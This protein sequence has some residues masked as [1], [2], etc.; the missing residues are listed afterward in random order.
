MDERSRH[1][2]PEHPQAPATAPWPTAPAPQPGAPISGHLP[3]AGGGF[4]LPG[5]ANGQPALSAHGGTI[6]LPLAPEHA[7][8]AIATLPGHAPVPAPMPPAH[9][10]STLPQAWA[11]P[12][13]YGM[14]L[15]QSGQPAQ[16]YAAAP[17]PAPAP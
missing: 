1:P 12:T 13:P 2:Y 11:F 9:P 8:P 3:H 6:G 16:A 7:A 10:M 14:Q 4:V 5:A 17:A 15:V